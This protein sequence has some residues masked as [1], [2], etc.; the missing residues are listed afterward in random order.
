MKF[1]T[2][3]KSENY[4][5]RV[6]EIKFIILHYT[7]MKSLDET[8]K[9]LCEPSSKVSCHYLV[10]KNGEIYQFISSEKRAWHAGDSYWKAIKDINSLSIGI[11]L[12]NS[13]HHIDFE[14]YTSNQIYALMDLIKDLKIQYN[15]KKTNILGHSDVAP[16][17]KMD[18]GEKFPWHILEKNNLVYLPKINKFILNNSPNQ[19]D[20]EKY[21]IN[22]KNIGYK[23]PKN[24][25][26]SD[27]F[28]K[29]NRAFQMHFQQ[30]FISNLPNFNT[31]MLA[32]KYVEEIID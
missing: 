14:E 17:R 20:I 16:L 21:K 30:D 5:I 25:H 26:N 29:T 15:I 4:D 19:D 6:G 8:I 18:P 22:L 10:T 23:L 1:I 27:Y 9:H 2:K 12:E 24:D 13:G 3:Y 32:Q 31:I 7:A 28:I 11:E